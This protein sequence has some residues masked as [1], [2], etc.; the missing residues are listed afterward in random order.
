VSKKLKNVFILSTLILPMDLKDRVVVITG[1]SRG[2]G[3]ALAEQFAKEGSRVIVSARTRS[4]L[5]EVAKSIN[6]LAIVADVTKEGDVQNLFDSVLEKF[7]KIEIMV[8]NAGIWMPHGPVEELDAK[9]T[10]DMVEVN[11]FGTIYCSKLALTQMR[12]HGYGVIVN[13]ISTSALEGRPN[14]SGYCASKFAVDGFCKSMRRETENSGIKIIN[15]YPGGIKTSLFDEHKAAVLKDYM[16]PKDV[17]EK[18]VNNLKQENP[19]EDQVIR[20]QSTV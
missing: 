15:V 11:L 5:E 17:A 3:K 7:G 19:Q 6:G 13:I 2:L 20:R 14:S 1:A 10:H 4:D 18:I 12:R 8:N 16:D 9:R